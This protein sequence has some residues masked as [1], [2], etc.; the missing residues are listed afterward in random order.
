ME[1]EVCRILGKEVG[2]VRVSDLYAVTSIKMVGNTSFEAEQEVS[3]ETHGTSIQADWEENTDRGQIVSLEDISAMPNLTELIL[4]N[5]CIGDLSPLRNSRIK[6]LY[7]HGNNISDISPLSECD[8]L[9][10]LIISSNRVSDFSPLL[11]CGFLSFLNAGANDMTDLRDIASIK[12]LKRL[13]LHD[14]PRLTDYS[15]L[16]EMNKLSA[17][18]IRPVNSTA[19]DAIGKM[20]E[21][22]WLGMWDMEEEADL[23]KLSA[24]TKIESIHMDGINVNSLEGMENFAQLSYLALYNMEA[25]SLHPLTKSE[26]LYTLDLRR[27]RF[28]DY[29]DVK[30]IP[31]LHDLYVSADQSESIKEWVGEGVNLIVY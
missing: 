12:S 31:A 17:F 15:A 20:T 11:D 24:L 25:E 7:L 29:S 13:Y 3:I 19:Y 6:R 16:N 9:E 1:A 22:T 30:D 14:C 23:N 8:Y 4:C 5:Q 2:T 18:S 21:L 27:C 26:N 10:E 28:D